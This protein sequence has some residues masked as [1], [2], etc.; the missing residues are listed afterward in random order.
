MEHQNDRSCYQNIC[1]MILVVLNQYTQI[2]LDRTATN[3]NRR[4]LFKEWERKTQGNCHRSIE[5]TI[6][7]V[8]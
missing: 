1:T 8:C 5:G 3:M 2:A 4:H 7:P 6:V